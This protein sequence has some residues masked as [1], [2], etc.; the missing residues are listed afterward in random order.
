MGE[1]PHDIA[2][3]YLA[4][5]ALHVEARLAEL[6]KLDDDKLAVHIA[7]ASDEQAWS[8]EFRSAA[9]LNTVGYLVDLHGW[10]LSWDDRG[11]RLS[12][13]TRSL[14]LGVPANVR[15]YIAGSV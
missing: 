6:A 2:D 3:V 7:M 9:V 1:L 12:H 5:V 15:R 8:P 4:P 10:S 14:V 11:V 13:G